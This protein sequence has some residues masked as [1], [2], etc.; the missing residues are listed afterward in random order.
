MFALAMAGL[1]VPAWS[2]QE[3]AAASTTNAAPSLAV[4]PTF[5]SVF[6]DDPTF[7]KDPF[8]PK[9]TRRQPKA[10]VAVPERVATLVPTGALQVRGLSVLNGRRLVILNTTTFA[11]GDEANVKV[12]NQTRRVKCV[13]IGD[14]TV[15]VE[16]DGVPTQLPVSIR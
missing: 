13:Q 2:A 15:A 10:A 5:K 12:G 1:G 8:F 4:S 7:G 11:E 3:A 16:I 9:S 14:Q 6:I